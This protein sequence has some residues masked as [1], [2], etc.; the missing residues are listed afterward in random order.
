[1]AQTIEDVNSRT[2][3]QQFHE[4]YNKQN[5]TETDVE[6]LDA[7]IDQETID[8][9]TA[10]L[11]I[12]SEIQT[13]RD[14]IDSLGV[15]FTYKGEVSTIQDLPV[16]DNKPGDVYYVDSE[17][18]GYVWLEKSGVYQWEEFGPAI[19]LSEYAKQEDLEQLED[20][21]DAMN[22]Q[23]ESNASNIV[24]LTNTK[25]D[26]LTAGTNI[27]I[28]Q[29][30]VISA[31]GGDKLYLHNIVLNAGGDRCIIYTTQQTVFTTQTLKD[32]I[33]NNNLTINVINSLT[34]GSNDFTISR[35]LYKN[36][37][38]NVEIYKNKISF[39][40][41]GTTITLNNSKQSAQVSVQSDIVTEL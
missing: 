4:L 23:V 16:T 39:T 6:N 19:D 9:Q 41:D 33:S 5:E 14:Q 18:S 30:N 13:L 24:N 15:L 35:Y 7:K 29:N 32:Y 26:K 36:A 34:A 40:T 11:S 37:Y 28:D 38:G 1:M 21:V 17:Q 25:Q 27:T 2:L 10:V 3:L 22:T 12:N 20:E 8:R 31:S